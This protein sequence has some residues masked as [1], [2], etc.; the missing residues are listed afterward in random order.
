MSFLLYLSPVLYHLI[1][2][3][4]NHWML[5]YDIYNGLRAVTS[6]IMLREVVREPNYYLLDSAGSRC[7][8][9]LY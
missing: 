1:S 5:V 6:G 3:V 2:R 9:L 7:D 4:L 8:Q